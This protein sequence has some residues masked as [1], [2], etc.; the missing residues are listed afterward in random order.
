MAG[1]ST[2]PPA[3]TWRMAEMKRSTSGH[4]M[5]EQIADSAAALVEQGDRAL[6]VD[7][8]GEHQ[9]GE[10]VDALGVSSSETTATSGR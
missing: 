1:S 10:V 3:A 9:D 2:E 7:A 5:L 4:A 8:L 6:V